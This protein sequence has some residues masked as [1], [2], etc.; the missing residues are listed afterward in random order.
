M[1]GIG[2]EQLRLPQLRDRVVKDGVEELILATGSTMEGQ[3]TA[4][5]I[6]DMFQGMEVRVTRLS[7]GVPMGSAL[8]FIDEGTLTTAL[9]ARRPIAMT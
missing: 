5:Y 4:Y 2:P 3:T 7:Q 8:D 1:E 9:A 6:A